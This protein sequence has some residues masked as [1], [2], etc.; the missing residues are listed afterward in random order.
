MFPFPVD[1]IDIVA[2]TYP[3]RYHDAYVEDMLTWAP[4][5]PSTFFLQPLYPGTMQPIH[6]MSPSSQANANT[7]VKGVQFKINSL[8]DLKNKASV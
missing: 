2:L 3:L 8:Q 5:T 1:E 6:P 7:P 4:L